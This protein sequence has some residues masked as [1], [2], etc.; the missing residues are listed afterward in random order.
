[1]YV[2][3]NNIPEFSND[4]EEY[5]RHK[6]IQ[7]I[8]TND[9]HNVE[10][11][12]Q[13]L[14]YVICLPAL[15]Q[16]EDFY[17]ACL[18]F[19]FEKR[20]RFAFINF[21]TPNWYRLYADMGRP[22]EGY[23][24]LRKVCKYGCLI[25]SLAK[26]SQKYAKEYYNKFSKRT[27]YCVWSPPINSIV[28]DDI[29]EEKR[30]QVLVFLRIRDKHKGGD[31]F[32]QL[33]GEYLRGMVCVCIVG[34]GEIAQGFL[35]EAQ[36]K[37]EQ[38]G[39]TL[40]FEKS[41]SDY[42]KFQEIKRSL[43]LFF[44]SHFEGYGYPPVEA[45]YCGTK[46]IAYDLPV[47]QEISGDKLIYCK[48]GDIS[49]MRQKAEIFLRQASSEYVCVDTADFAKQA[50]RLQNILEDNLEN[51]KLIYKKIFRR[52]ISWRIRKWYYTKVKGKKI[53]IPEII[54]YCICNDVT[55]SNKLK[56]SEEKW[57]YVRKQIQ[58]KN[59]YVW[60][61]GRAYQELYP[62][63]KNKIKIQGVV[64]KSPNKVGT[65]D[66][67]SGNKIIQNP[68]ILKDKDKEATV[69]LVSNKEGVDE[70]IKQLED[71]GIKNYHS[72]CMMELNAYSSKLYKV[73]NSKK[74]CAKQ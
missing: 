62:K 8:I 67:V 15:G 21:E 31:D 11:K 3:T 35:T 41:L 65:L 58:G 42:R 43:L 40:R 57:K 66:R 38:Y 53:G 37:A 46:C 56:N 4:F 10:L 30:N 55:I 23:E 20:A 28:A 68:S 54:R 47:L 33:I 52:E 1:M 6:E 50:E 64:D 24:T 70:I 17:T 27:E 61:C 29:K 39:I 19:A 18:D 48:R 72:L 44:P 2:I 51:A 34:N 63:Y 9:F 5:P 73:L 45:L 26:E 60:G 25:F 14:D 69:V 74:I 36:N 13:R 49:M 12:E 71:M 7:I 16:Q 32:L 22:E 59:I